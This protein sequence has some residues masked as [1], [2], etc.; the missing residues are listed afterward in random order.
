MAHLIKKFVPNLQNRH[1]SFF[2]LTTS[3]FLSVHIVRRKQYSILSPGG[4]FP[5][6]PFAGNGDTFRNFSG[7]L[8]GKILTKVLPRKSCR[9]L[10]N[11]NS[12]QDLGFWFRREISFAAFVKT[13]RDLTRPVDT[14]N[15]ARLLPFRQDFSEHV[16]TFWRFARLC[17]FWRENVR[18]WRY[19]IALGNYVLWVV[20]AVM[21]LIHIN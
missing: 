18:F 7:S 3:L 19:L 6:L 20:L 10:G 8:A 15:L 1:I 4:F 11:Q 21:L 17:S 14:N 12:W 2:P 9:D 5:E 13:W 16:S